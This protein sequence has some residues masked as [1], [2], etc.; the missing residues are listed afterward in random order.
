MA[1]D[2]A[3]ELYEK[4]NR[5]FRGKYEKAQLFGS[6]ISET[7][8]KLNAGTATFIDANMYADEVGILL[9]DTLKECIS[10]EEMP[11][12][13]FYYNIAERTVGTALQDE[14]GLVSNVAGMIQEQLNEANGIG[15]KAVVPEPNRFRINEIVDRAARAE[16]QQELSAALGKPVQTFVRKATDDTIKANAKLHNDAGLEVKIEREYDGVGLHD[17]TDTCD[18]CLQRAGTWTY[19]KARANGV[20]ERHEGCGCIIDYTSKKGVRTRQESKYSGWDEVQE[21][22]QRIEEANRR[23]AEMTER[24]RQRTEALTG[25]RTG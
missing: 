7:L 19:D 20:F 3:P 13:R 18:W 17:G 4:I 2:I 5:I 25:R 6:Q 8:S 21:R 23:S 14:Y 24:R 1:A 10:L 9:S 11:G 22:E 15:L 12:G 16:T